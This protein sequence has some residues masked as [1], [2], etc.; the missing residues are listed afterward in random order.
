[1]NTIRIR[2]FYF[3]FFAL[4]LI[5]SL[6][7]G[8]NTSRYFPFLERPENYLIKSK[9]FFSPTLF[10]TT[11]SSAFKRMH[12]KTGIPELW[13]PYDLKDIIA[14]LEAVKKGMGEVFTNPFLD[15]PGVEG[16][17]DRSILFDVDGKVT[18]LG[19]F[20]EGAHQLFSK[21]LYI[22][23]SIPFMHVEARSRYILRS[24]STDKIKIDP[25]VGALLS[26]E[27]NQVERVRLDVHKDLGIE[28]FD[29]P[30]TGFGDLDC[31]LRW[32]VH[33]NHIFLM[34]SID[35]NI[36]GGIVFPTSV[37]MDND[38][39]ASVPF[40]GNGHVGFYIDLHS[41]F[42]LKHDIKVRTLT[43]FMFQ[44]PSTRTRRIAVYKESDIFSAL[45]GRVKVT[46]GNTFK[47]S[48]YITFENILD[49]LHLHG[50]YTYLRHSEDSR[51]DK[52]DDKT[53]RSYLEQIPDVDRTEKDIKDNIDFKKKL[54]S[55][56]A[57]YISVQIAYEPKAALQNWKLDPVFYVKIDTPYGGSGISKTHHISPGAI[58][59]F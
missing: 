55:W 5:P 11:A 12:G 29:W 6:F 45:I 37:M 39:P 20:L 23:F 30:Q 43:S 58:L 52:R 33:G 56:R 48:S 15:T 27:L 35:I 13:G 24:K 54:S 10:S 34:R 42:E 25:V 19:I 40:M 8:H 1:M 21:H 51:H 41:E 9:R 16:L 17:V 53:I 22:G 4:L 47:F 49:G 57:H 38:N 59:R 7:S 46:P 26:G 50:R 2:F 32:N 31:Y 18:S 44:A 3:F 14:S 36:L 28:P